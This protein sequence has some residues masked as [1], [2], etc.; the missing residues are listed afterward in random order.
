MTPIE[1]VDEGA[2]LADSFAGPPEEFQLAVPDSLLDPVGVNMAIITDHVLK[3]GWEP[4]AF[5]QLAVTESID[6]R[7]SGDVFA[8]TQQAAGT[9]SQWQGAVARGTEAAL[10]VKEVR[11]SLPGLRVK[12]RMVAWSGSTDSRELRR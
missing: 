10:C 3:R 4:N 12:F 1:S 6:T 2:H 8:D 11:Q 5:T 9:D 7:R